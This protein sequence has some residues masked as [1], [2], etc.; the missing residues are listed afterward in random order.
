M[1]RR[2][3]ASPF[4]RYRDSYRGAVNASIGFSGADVDFLAKLKALDIVDTLDRRLGGAAQARVLDVGCG[5]GLTDVH[6][7]GR[8]GELHGADVAEGLLEAAAADNPAVHYRSFDGTTLPYAD[9]AFDA[10]FAIC[11][12]HHVEPANR[13][14]LVHEM[15][16]VT[17]RGGLV[18]IY[19]HN[20]F[21]PL[22]RLAVSRCEFDVGVELLRPGHARR[23]LRTAKAPP[24]ES[25]FITFFPWDSALLQSV[26]RRLS[27]LPLGGQFVVVGRVAE[28]AGATS[29]DPAS[30]PRRH[31]RRS[32]RRA[33]TG[34]SR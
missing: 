33:G 30:R 16:R 2:R 34:R 22:T 7:V 8:V 31:R 19:E 18:A 29:A 5:A 20:P 13:S 4:D 15:S 27:R 6:L 25:R 23:L 1:A 21:N 32:S 24:V 14:A 9:G 17:R 26:E 28:A 12:L 11:V 3:S 10:A